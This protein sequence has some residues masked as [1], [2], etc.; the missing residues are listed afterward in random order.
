M[1]DTTITQICG[2]CRG[3]GGTIGADGPCNKRQ[4]LI[5]N[6]ADGCQLRF[7]AKTPGVRAKGATQQSG[8]EKGMS[9]NG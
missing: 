2:R 5:V 3:F 4:G 9:Q 7:E 1:A 8:R 6:W